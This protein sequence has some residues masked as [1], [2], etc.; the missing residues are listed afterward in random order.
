MVPEV[1]NLTCPGCGAPI[2]NDE[3]ICDSCGRPL[4]IQNVK[5][6]LDL[7][8]MQVK[9]YSST[10]KQLLSD[11]PF[12]SKVWKANGL[13]QIKLGLY[14][15]ALKSFEKA[16][17]FCF[18]D[19]DIHFYTAIAKLAGKRP[20]FIKRDDLNGALQELDAALGIEK[21]GMY[22]YLA[23]VITYDYFA[24]KGFKI[25]PNCVE[26]FENAERYGCS[27]SDIVTLNELLKFDTRNLPDVD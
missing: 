27:E 17:E 23:G 22:E 4:V 21:K 9:K 18:D 12:N 6:L 19:G 24:R 16:S 13:T 11:D 3:K 25:S 20:A 1:V 26:H 2:L 14:P 7:D 15:A 8:D 5:T 10:Y